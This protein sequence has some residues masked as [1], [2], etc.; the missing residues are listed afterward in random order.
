MFSFMYSNFNLNNMCLNN[1]LGNTIVYILVEWYCSSKSYRW[2]RII[3]L[4]CVVQI[5]Y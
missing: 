2:E 5:K 3:R 1:I 4:R